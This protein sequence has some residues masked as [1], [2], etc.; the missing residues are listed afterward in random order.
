MNLSDLPLSPT[1]AQPS[2]QPSAHDLL[3]LAAQ[4]QREQRAFAMVTVLR[5]SAPTAAKPGDK[6]LVVADGTLH[7]WIGGGCAHGA[8]L[9]SAQQA[10]ADGV[11]RVIRVQPDVPDADELTQFNSTCPSGGSTELFVE[12][13]LPAAQLVV[14]GDS[15]VAQALAALSPHIDLAVTPVAA[16]ASRLPQG[17]WCVVATQGQGDAA[18]LRTALASGARHIWLVASARK[19]MVLKRGLI[20]DGLSADA[21]HAITAPAGLD[22]GAR[23]P[24]EVALSILA[25]VVQARR[26]APPPEQAI[27]TDFVA[28]SAVKQGVTAGFGTQAAAAPAARS[29]CAG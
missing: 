4:W 16:D 11:P 19:A 10:L 28:V 14:L 3:A 8:V 21:V 29:C 27:A 15:P 26:A 24:A 12:P 6:A 22:I 20:A 2:A 9:K 17:G 1:S 25:A 5:T 7:G 18:A 13:Y 23:T